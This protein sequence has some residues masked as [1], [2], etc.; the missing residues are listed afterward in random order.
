MHDVTL[1]MRW[2]QMTIQNHRWVKMLASNSV[3][4][5]AAGVPRSLELRSAL[6]SAATAQ[7]KQKALHAEVATLTNRRNS[8]LV[9][10]EIAALDNRLRIIGDELRELEKL[11]QTAFRDVEHHRP[12]YAAA[13]KAAL[14]QRRRDAAA[15]AVA[16]IT[17]FQNATAELDETAAAIKAAGGQARQLPCFPLLDGI[18]R[19]A[20]AIERET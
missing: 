10:S 1:V 8:L 2:L 16:A 18:K 6:D 7:A 11:R 19:L 3:Q 14:S 13:V 17:A 4:S 5:L 12:T 20:Q 15:R 9:T